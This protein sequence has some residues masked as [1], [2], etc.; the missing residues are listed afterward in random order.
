M[1]LFVLI[2]SVSLATLGAF[3]V[4]LF[5]RKKKKLP[6]FAALLWMAA[7][8]GLAALVLGLMTVFPF[9]AQAAR[10]IWWVPAALFIWG[11]LTV[12]HDLWPRNRADDSTGSWSLMLPV[13]AALAGGAVP[14][15]VGRFAAALNSG[16]AAAFAAMF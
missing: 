14:G 13:L 5:L 16:A 12:V 9:L 8:A 2:T 6:K 4:G 1:D 11:L 7:G 10:F 15:A 3:L